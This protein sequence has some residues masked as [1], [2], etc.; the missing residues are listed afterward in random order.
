[1]N[2]RSFIALFFVLFIGIIFYISVNLQ[3]E[4]LLFNA[5]NMSKHLDSHIVR[6]VDAVNFLN[7]AASELMKKIDAE[8]A[9]NIPLKKIDNTG[10]FNLD[11]NLYFKNTPS[12]LQVAMATQ[13][14]FKRDHETLR[15]V[16]MS[17]ELAPYFKT[18]KDENE[19]YA[20]LYYFSNSNFLTLYPFIQNFRLE[21]DLKNRPLFQYGTKQL[22]KEK[23]LFMTPPYLDTVGKGLMITLGKPVYNK[24]K[25]LGITE[26]D[27]TLDRL[28]HLMQIADLLNNKSL[29]INKQFQVLGQNNLFFQKTKSEIKK[30]E[31]VAPDLQNTINKYHEEQQVRLIDFKYIYVTKLKSLPLTFVYYQ[32]AYLVWAKALFQT[33]PAFLLIFIIFYIYRSYNKIK[34]LNK[35]LSDSKEKLQEEASHD[36]MTGLYNRRYFFENAQAI[37]LKSQRKNKMLA[38]CM[39]DLDNFKMIN[40]TY[41]HHEGDKFIIA[42]SDIISKHL[43]ESDLVARFGGDEFCVLLE[44]ITEKNVIA[45]F[46][47]IQSIYN[48]YIAVLPFEVNTSLSIGIAYGRF[49]TIEKGIDLADRA[50]YQSKENGKNQLTLKK[51][52]N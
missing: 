42:L 28:N 30:I 4:S 9:P 33:I 45:L 16:A 19:E 27:I 38:I 41:G 13:S 20:W 50:L 21:A 43:R 46:E 8:K 51:T 23:K 39:L 12:D 3:K 29:L 22:N 31:K 48:D 18:L 44:D 49:T 14:G 15:E 24:D 47:K 34:L 5:Y 1:M 2:V 37:L 40:D 52:N 17:L 6:A 7:T 35:E 32:S 36:F 25:F 26:V 11:Y 10:E